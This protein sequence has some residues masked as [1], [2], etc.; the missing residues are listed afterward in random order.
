MFLGCVN[1][2]HAENFGKTISEP[3]PDYSQNVIKNGVLEA[4]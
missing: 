3:S 4:S 1:D 2:K